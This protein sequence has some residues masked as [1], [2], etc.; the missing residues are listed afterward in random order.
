MARLRTVVPPIPEEVEF[1][2]DVEDSRG[3]TFQVNETP[4]PT[5]PAGGEMGQ[6]WP[7][8]PSKPMCATRRP[9][10]ASQVN[11]FG[12]DRTDGPFLE[13]ETA[14]CDDL[15]AWIGAW[16]PPGAKVS[17]GPGG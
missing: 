7:L 9:G 3:L 17:K 4:L 15:Q 5:G 14:V 16:G 1:F 10:C 12:A 6:E 11:P 8:P 13:I 2:P